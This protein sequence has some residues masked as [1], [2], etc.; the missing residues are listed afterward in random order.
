MTYKEL[1]KEFNFWDA[2]YIVI[3]NALNREG[4]SLRWAMQKPPISKKNRKL[5]LAFTKEHRKWTFRNWCSILW[6]NKT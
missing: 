2:R 1:A 6:S 3:K 4:F 5:R